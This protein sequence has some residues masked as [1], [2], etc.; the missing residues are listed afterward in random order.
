LISYG[1]LQ[2]VIITVLVFCIWCR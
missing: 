2:L 1:L